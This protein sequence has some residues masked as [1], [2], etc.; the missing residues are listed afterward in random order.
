MQRARKIISIVLISALLFGSIPCF[1]ANQLLTLDEA[2]AQAIKNSFDIKG[3]R[4]DLIS[5]D[6]ARNQAI[7]AIA[8]IRKKESTVRFSL[9]FNIEFPETHGL[10]K[11]IDLIM[12]IPTIE[13][14]MAILKKKIG[15]ETLK[16]AYKA[17]YAYYDVLLSAYNKT[18]LKAQEED[19][20][21]TVTKIS[22]QVSIG[23][24]DPKD[25]EYIQKEYDKIVE[26]Y[27]TA[28][29]KHEAN[30]D[31]LSGI[32]GFD[33]TSG[34]DFDE[35]ALTT[36][37]LQR[38]QL[39]AIVAYGKSKDF[40]L[41]SESQHTALAMRDVRE[42][43]SIYKNEF[44][45]KVS[46]LDSQL[47]KSEIDVDTFYAKYSQAL[48]NIDQ[49]WKKYYTINMLFFKIRI[50]KR[51]FQGEYDA[52]RY[53]EDEKYALFLSVLA[54]EKQIAQEKNAIK[55]YEQQIKDAFSALKDMER[56]Y[57]DGQTSLEQLEKDYQKVLRDNQI[58]LVGFSEL[59]SAKLGFNKSQ[60][61]L[62][63]TF[64]EYNKMIASF[65][66]ATSGY[67]D[68]FRGKS[69]LD[70][71]ALDSG[72][73]FKVDEET[74]GVQPQWHVSST[75]DAYK[76]VFGITLPASDTFTHYELFTDTNV[77]VGHRVKIDETITH[78]P[79]VFDE[80]G[81]FYVKL[82]N[83]D[84]QV[85]LAKVDGNGESGDL[86]IDTGSLEIPIGAKS[87]LGSYEF[88][89]TLYSTGIRIK[90]IDRINYDHFNVYYNGEV[91]G[92]FIEKDNQFIHIAAF[93]QDVNSVEIGLVFNG[94]EA[95]RLKL[96]DGQ[97]VNP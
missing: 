57:E 96:D 62:H 67:I 28:V 42:I 29:T 17:E 8:D 72:D 50:P 54:K 30:K 94:K 76:F 83:K 11:E 7:Q 4:M 85:G 33:V 95:F 15:Y 16:T 51:W 39:N 12:K 20:S 70:D 66:L 35:S 89:K 36:I 90:V 73:S 25:L 21:E 81:S 53:F 45:S 68:Q 92:E 13:S 59:E 44:G 34:Y 87:V 27:K 40:S 82:Y 71:S 65:N 47:H 5:K 18:S 78:L 69:S 75:V 10:P 31:K 3:V 56:A 23:T 63:E 22:H 32:V 86:I 79:F 24:G 61:A 37:D 52:L 48:K 14:E 58:G 1:A 91:V 77:Q 6:I 46:V 9:L 26:A 38:S 64:V 97:L 41:Y 55:E 88:V 49:P 84:K 43:S 2:V 93:E 19:L 74:G 80:V 60:D